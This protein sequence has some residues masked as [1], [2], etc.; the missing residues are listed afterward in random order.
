M[1]IEVLTSFFMWCTIMNGAL[2]TL[3]V[4]FFMAA[5]DLVYRTQSRFFSIPRDAFDV[6]MYCFLGMFKIFFLVF[7]LI[8]YLAL[9]II[10]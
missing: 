10:G 3:W 7:N 1:T 9:L 2:L 4:G 8:P 5:P 6:V